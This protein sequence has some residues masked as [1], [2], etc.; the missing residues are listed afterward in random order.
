MPIEHSI[1]AARPAGGQRR[2]SKNA[3][4]PLLPGVR[5]AA[6]E[7]TTIRPSKDGPPA[8]IRSASRP[9]S[10][11]RA[12]RGYPTTPLALGSAWNRPPQRRSLL[13]VPL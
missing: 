5:F 3:R 8:P 9:E 1:G 12:P 10:G 11:V 6:N 2:R 4:E 13:E 7:R